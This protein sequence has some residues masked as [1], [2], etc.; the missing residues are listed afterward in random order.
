MKPAQMMKMMR[1]AVPREI[2]GREFIFWG[3][4]GGW[5]WTRGFS[6]ASVVPVK[7]LHPEGALAE[8]VIGQN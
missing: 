2:S 1:A 8:E 4:Q 7:R 5:V 6:V 3:N